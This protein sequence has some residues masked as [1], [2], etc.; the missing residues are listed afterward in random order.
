MQQYYI[1][2]YHIIFNHFS[3]V[4]ILCVV[5]YLSIYLLFTIPLCYLVVSRM[6]ILGSHLIGIVTCDFCLKHIATNHVHYLPVHLV[7]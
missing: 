5:L 1:Y 2:S 7:I 3:N 6:H 4:F